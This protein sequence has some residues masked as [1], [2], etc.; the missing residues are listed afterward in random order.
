MYK[1]TNKVLVAEINGWAIYIP[2]HTGRRVNQDEVQSLMRLGIVFE[3][4]NTI[5]IDR[6]KQQ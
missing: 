3:L 6:C 2:L 4:A 1:L 5:A